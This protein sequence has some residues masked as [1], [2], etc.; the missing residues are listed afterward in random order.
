MLTNLRWFGRNG[1][2]WVRKRIGSEWVEEEG[3]SPYFFVR[4]A[5]EKHLPPWVSVERG[6]WVSVEGEKCVKVSVSLPSDVVPLRDS[7]MGF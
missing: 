6:D 1:K 2:T 5:D 7:F 3:F 4:E